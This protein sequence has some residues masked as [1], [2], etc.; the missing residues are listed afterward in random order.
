M[1]LFNVGY[2]NSFVVFEVPFSLTRSSDILFMLY[3]SWLTFQWG[4][5]LMAREK[6]IRVATHWNSPAKVF[7]EELWEN[8][9]HFFLS[10]LPVSFFFLL[11]FFRAPLVHRPNDGV[12]KHLWN[13]GQ[14]TRNYTAQNS[15]R[16]SSLYLICWSG[17]GT[18][19]SL[20]Y[21]YS[22]R[23][24]VQ[25]PDRFWDQFCLL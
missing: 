24:R 10:F 17:N 5:V 11:F 16:L 21:N 23:N 6:I 13:I 9:L 4:Q 18:C 19:D 2:W 7:N 15:R 1:I 8:F 14:F 12:S 3:L 20:H 22:I 25:S